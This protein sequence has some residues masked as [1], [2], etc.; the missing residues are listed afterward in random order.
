MRRREIGEKE[1]GHFKMWP[2]CHS[3]RT[4]SARCT[5]RVYGESVGKEMKGGK[6]EIRVTIIHMFYFLPSTKVLL[7]TLY[8]FMMTTSLR[9]TEFS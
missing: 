4:E 6:N 1:I 3:H 5:C 9:F 8:L 7:E 2:I